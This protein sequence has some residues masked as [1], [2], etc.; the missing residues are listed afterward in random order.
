MFVLHV[1]IRIKPG[2]E[3][4]SLRSVFAGAFLF[5][6]AISAQLG[7]PGRPIPQASGGRRVHVL[8]IAFWKV[9]RRSSSAW[10][11]TDLH[12]RVWPQKGSQFSTAIASQPTTRSR[13]ESLLHEIRRPRL[14]RRHPRVR[15]PRHRPIPM[16]REGNRLFEQTT[17]ATAGAR[18]CSKK[19]W[20]RCEE[21]R[22]RPC[23]RRGGYLHHGGQG[24]ADIPGGTN[25]EPDPERL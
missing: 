11:V 13:P 20:D 8:A 7:V 2:Q 1:T 3:D 24:S 17:P 25:P 5:K 6:A 19:L 16:Q 22:R 12:T 10:V 23:H 14:S 4:A 15:L 21:S 18:R 9:S